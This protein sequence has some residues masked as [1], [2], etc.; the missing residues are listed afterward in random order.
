MKLIY[1]VHELNHIFE[2]LTL[3]QPEAKCKPIPPE[4]YHHFITEYQKSEW[5]SAH[6]DAC[7]AEYIASE[8]KGESVDV[9]ERLSEIAQETIY[10]VLEP[11]ISFTE[12]TDEPIDVKW[13]FA[14]GKIAA[15]IDVVKITKFE[16]M[17]WDFANN[18]K[19][20]NEPGEV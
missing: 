15:T 18:F 12:C 8:Y 10:M 7:I 16:D 6:L 11:I 9:L 5:D 13:D 3:L 20:W 19:K 4:T 2:N 17:E 14:D 1:G